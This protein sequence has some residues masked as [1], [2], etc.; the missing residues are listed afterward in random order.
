VSR[1]LALLTLAAVAVRLVSGFNLRVLSHDSAHLLQAAHLWKEGRFNEAL[2]LPP[3]THPLFP[4]LAAAGEAVTGL[5]WSAAVVLCSVLGGLGLLPLHALARRV[6]GDRTA[7]VSS[8]L[9]AFLPD[10]VEV[11]GNALTYGP[12]FFFFLSALMLAWTAFERS[13]W[14]RAL[15]AGLA[16]AAAWL[17]RPEGVYL[18][19]LIILAALVRPRRFAPL[20]IALAL[21]AAFVGAFPYLAFIKARTGKAGI[22][23]NPLAKGV[24]GL[25][26]GETPA[27][28]YEVTEKT[29][30]EFGE[31][32]YIDR[33]GR[34]GGPILFVAKTSA[35]VLFYIL[36]PFLGIGLALL[37]RLPRESWPPAG[38]LLAA[39]GGAFVP[40]VLAFVAATPFSYRYVL[41]TFIL[42]LP[43]VAAGI[44]W[45]TDRL[46]R[47]ER[48]LS[49]LLGALC[50]A[51]TVR[52]CR[53]R[54][55]D[56]VSLKEA[57]HWILERYGPGIRMAGT[58]RE[59]EYYARGEFIA[60]PPDLT[61]DALLEIIR[62]E[63]LQIVALYEP[64]LRHFEPDLE[65]RL[66]ESFR[67]SGQVPSNPDRKR[68]PVRLY[69][70]GG[71]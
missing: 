15:L 62:R 32:R 3:A 28:G 40:P 13:S 16:T 18:V 1:R 48:T 39:A 56:R 22:T 47:R 44:L 10:A 24:F 29:A 17:T 42:L 30:A 43:V 46:P 65:R 70:T 59:M 14:E 26:T 63:R 69:W 61:Y 37:P 5:R 41:L 23:Y 36:V 66:A 58:R 25:L 7:W 6:W 21:A 71:S 8:V 64:D 4:L 11:Q 57:G 20:G 12:F 60:L 35:R 55:G 49:L 19:P 45:T 54:N 31:Y 33:Y 2:E 67:L 50:L 51:M 34:V 27:T 9:Y 38:Y 52:S 68:P 53:P